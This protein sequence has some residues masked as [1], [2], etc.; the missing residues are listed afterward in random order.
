MQALLSLITKPFPVLLGLVAAAETATIFRY[1]Y[2]PGLVR[3]STTLIAAILDHEGTEC[4]RRATRNLGDG[5][6]A[7]THATRIRISQ[8]PQVSTA[9]EGSPLVAGDVDRTSKTSRPANLQ[10]QDYGH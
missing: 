4:L 6:G 1:G 8:R 9:S 2:A 3:A 10:P 5:Y 7:D